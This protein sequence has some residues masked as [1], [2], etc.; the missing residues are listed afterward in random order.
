MTTEARPSDPIALEV[1]KNALGAIAEEM[2]LTTV[3]SAYSSVVKEGGD[4]TAAIFDRRGQFIAQSMGAPLMHLSSLRP[5]LRS[6][7]DDFPPSDMADGD[8]YASNDPYRGG[9]HSNDVMVFRPVFIDGTLAF[10]TCALLHVADLGGMAAGGLPANATEMFQEG[11]VLPP[12]PLAKAGVPNQPM[13]D[14][15]AANSRTPEKVLGDIRAM[16]AA[17]NLGADRLSELSA[18]YGLERLHQITDELLDYTERRTRAGIEALADGIY[19]GSFIIDDDGV[20]PDA[21]HEVHVAL[22]INGSTITADF[23]GTSPQAPGPINAAV[24]QTTSGV[25]FAVRCLLAPDIPV[26][27]GAF[28]PLEL[29]LPRGTL[30]N[31]NPPAALNARMATVMAVVEAM[32][33]AFAQLDPARAVAASCNVHVYIMNGTGADGR[34]WAFMDPQFGG[35]GARSDRDGVDVTGPLV[36]G[37]GG[38]F[39][40]VEA[41]EQEHPVRFERFELWTDSGGPGQWRG[42]TGSRRDIRILTDGQFTGRATDRCRRPPPGIYGGAPGAGG[43]WV[44]NHGTPEEQPLPAK[45]TAYPLQAGDVITML[46]S[47]GGGYGNP[48]DRDPDLVA[49]DVRDG[50]VSPE[51]ARRDYGVVIDPETGQVDQTATATLRSRR[52]TP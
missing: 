25:L 42:G 18:R 14:V 3:R 10:F 29:R 28:R 38:A 5:S 52:S 8:V 21:D 24:S 4:S 23:E 34:P 40:T 15:I 7:L 51:A 22:T 49:T 1:V 19:T 27:D 30:V 11:L 44:L 32:L 39:H 16:M 46:T 12:V 35:S 13:L 31:P 17:T 20:N 43:G 47:A 33:G 48:F 9:I 37:A 26:N 6:L 36:L 50:G 2:G 41:Y 45:V